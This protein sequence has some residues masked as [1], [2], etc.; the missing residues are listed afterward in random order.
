MPFSSLYSSFS[1]GLSSSTYALARVRHGSA[2]IEVPVKPLPR[3]LIEETLNPFYIFQ[4]LGVL[5]W[6]QQDYVLYSICIV[7]ISVVSIVTSL[8]ETRRNLENIRRMAHY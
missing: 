8:R 5:L 4:F 2:S 7:V 3:L 1:Q 6:L